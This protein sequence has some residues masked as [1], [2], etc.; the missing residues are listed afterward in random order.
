MFEEQ[1]K[2]PD[3]RIGAHEAQ[4]DGF[5]DVVDGLKRGRD[6][7]LH[8]AR[9][10]WAKAEVEDRDRKWPLSSM[11]VSQFAIDRSVW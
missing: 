1:A 5:Q 2:T 7:C 9:A 8:E 10:G 6:E 11:D 3:R 4:P